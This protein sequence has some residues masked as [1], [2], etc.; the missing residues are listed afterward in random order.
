[1]DETEYWGRLEYR[2]CDELTGFEDKHLRYYWCDGL[3]PEE[4][5]L[6]G[7]QKR[8][9]GRAWMGN[10]HRMEQW[11]F[12]LLTV[13]AVIAKEEIDWAALLPEDWLTGWLTP[14]PQIKSLMIDPL[15]GYHD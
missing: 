14:D 15:S 8:I 2:I 12:T 11:D 10:G 4:Y 13:P 5:D 7:E 6:L 1:L 9:H 3:I